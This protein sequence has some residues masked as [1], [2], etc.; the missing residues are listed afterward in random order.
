MTNPACPVTGAPAVR[1]VQ[2][3]ST[4]FLI[5]LWRIIFHV[6]ARASF[7]QHERIGL[8]ESPTG[9]Y[10]FDPPL[11]G[12]RAFYTQFYDVLLRRKLWSHDAIRHEFELAGR[13]IGAGAQ[14][15]DVG[16]GFASFR[17]VIP[18]ARYLGLDPNVADRPSTAPR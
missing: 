16:C 4:K 8:W 13:R 3:I 1:L 7:G 9:L 5:S 11:E 10:F 18:H 2:W 17:Q 15:L 14:V 12:D 6:D